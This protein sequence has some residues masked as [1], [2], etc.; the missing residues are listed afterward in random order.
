MNITG[1]ASDP[2]GNIYVLD[3]GDLNIRKVDATGL[4]TTLAGRLVTTIAGVPG[5]S[6]FA[7]G[8]LPG[9]LSFPTDVAPVGSNLYI[10]MPTA[11]AVV[12]DR[13]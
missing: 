8:S 5:S 6:M 2:Y 9:G 13:P 1:M 3:A 10:T 12:R 4:V 7:P 11:I